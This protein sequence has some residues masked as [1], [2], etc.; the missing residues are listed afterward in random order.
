VLAPKGVYV[1]I[2][3]GG[4]QDG[5]WIGPFGKVVQGMVLSAFGDQEYG[6]L[7]ASVTPED[8]TYLGELMTARK[9]VP[10]IDRRYTSLAEVPDA[11]AYLERGRARGKVIV[12]P[13]AS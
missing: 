10:V 8:L 4:P 5:R 1:L 2:G 7:L 13:D 12:A 3:A 9:V 6:M 11:L